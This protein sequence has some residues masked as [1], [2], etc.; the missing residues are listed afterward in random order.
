MKPKIEEIK[1]NID[2]LNNELK[3][4][5]IKHTHRIIRKYAG[6]IC[7]RCYN[8]PTK[9][10]TYDVGDAELVERYCDK[11]FND[12]IRNDGRHKKDIDK[13]N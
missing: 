6:G 11:C 1:I 13:L 5:S 4:K 8:I 9:K 7:T 12:S 2:E 3:L 10:I